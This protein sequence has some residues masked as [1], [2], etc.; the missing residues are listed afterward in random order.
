MPN[1]HFVIKDNELVAQSMNV[2]D[3]GQNN[4]GIKRRQPPGNEL[5]VIHHRH[6]IRI[7]PSWNLVVGE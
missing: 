7:Q 3:A 2:A 6:P 5:S 4:V 1:N